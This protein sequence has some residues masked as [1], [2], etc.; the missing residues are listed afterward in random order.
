[1]SENRLADLRR[2]I[3]IFATFEGDNIVLCQ[4]ACC[5]VDGLL[6][7]KFGGCCRCRYIWWLMWLVVVVVGVVA[8]DVVGG[9]GCW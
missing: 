3:D 5:W 9:C 8:G 1:M 7:V 4:Q 6:L 2:D